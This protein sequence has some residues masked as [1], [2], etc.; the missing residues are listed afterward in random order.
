MGIIRR[1]TLISAILLFIYNIQ[2]QEVITGLQYNEAVKQEA[3][4]LAKN[5]NSDRGQ[6]NESKSLELPFLDDFSTSN[7]YPD[8]TKWVNSRSVFINKDIPYLPP[9]IGGATFDA[10]DSLGKVYPNALWIPF[11]AD[12]MT[13]VPIRLDSVFSPVA[14][15]LSPADSVYLSFFYQPQGHG[16]AP[17]SADSLLLQFARKGDS[18][19]Q[20]VDSTYE[21]SAQFFLVDQNDTL[22]PGD[23]LHPPA[24]LGCDTTITWINEG[25]YTW[26]DFIS[27]PCDSVFGPKTVWETKWYAEGMKLDTFY[28]YN[29]GKYFVQV[30]VPIYDSLADTVYFNDSFRF[31][32]RNYAS[33]ATDIEP[34]ERSNCDHWNI[35]YVYLNYNRTKNDTSYRV[36]S[37]TERAPSFLQNYQSMPYRQY[38]ADATNAVSTDFE[39]KISN[40]DKIAHN[41]KYRY[42]VTQVNGDFNYDFENNFNV[43]PGYN[44]RTGDVQKLF[45]FDFSRDTTSYIIKHYISDTSNPSNILVDSAIYHQGFYNY[46]AYD[47]GTPE[48]GYGVK[49]IGAMVA[50]QFKLS[51]PDTLRGVQ[52]YFNRTKDNANSVYFNI[53]VWRDNNGQPGEIAYEMESQKP[54]WEEGLYRFHAYMFND[55]VVLSGTFYIGWEIRADNLL[56]V[57]FD[58][59]SYYGYPRIYINVDNNNWTQ[60]QREGSLLLRPIVGPDMILS[61]RNYTADNE[62]GLLIYPNPASDNFSIVLSDQWLNQ[63]LTVI[64]YNLYGSVVFEKTGTF[65]NIS[66]SEFTQ[67][68][69]IVKVSSGTKVFTGKLLV[70]H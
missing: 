9:T 61:N 5:Q 14:R 26:D 4:K 20:Y 66:T 13:S 58:A 65:E 27:I 19:F 50:C 45:N 2:G 70:N 46:F 33:I 21:V 8:A 34:S 39:M 41:S 53:L 11:K 64:I 43:S 63:Q 57:G 22:K 29:H 28:E 10:I 7:I 55:P 42:Q 18:V 37:F 15:A 68:M 67:G 3:L 56:N 47:D 40:L 51:T 62:N 16:E 69:Y 54:Q 30:M 52:I 38:R 23:T 24:E 49:P 35:D 59:N 31:R 12:V 25:I 48:F 6:L 32:F 44:T 17:E 36:L 60:S 1:F